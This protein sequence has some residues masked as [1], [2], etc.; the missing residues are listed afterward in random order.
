MPAED[1]QLSPYAGSVTGVA[2]S[3]GNIGP[4]IMP[5]IFGFLIDVTGSF[6]TSIIAVAFL[7]GITFTLGSKAFS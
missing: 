3:L 1:K 4:F 2:S 5:V 7:A 6:Q